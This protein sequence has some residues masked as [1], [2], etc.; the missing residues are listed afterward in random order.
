MARRTL[1]QLILEPWGRLWARVL[2]LVL[3]AV[4][5]S[6]QNSCWTPIQG[7]PSYWGQQ[8]VHVPELCATIRWLGMLCRESFPPRIKTA[9]TEK[10][11]ESHQHI[12][13]VPMLFRDAGCKQIYLDDSDTFGE[14]NSVSQRG[15]DA[16]SVPGLFEYWHCELKLNPRTSCKVPIRPESI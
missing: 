14:D 13:C 12:K 10:L 8:D 16:P 11:M 3:G 4:R 9:N 15:S 2:L 5:T 1:K 7:F 6:R